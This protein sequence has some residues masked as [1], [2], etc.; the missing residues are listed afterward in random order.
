MTSENIEENKYSNILINNPYSKI[1]DLDTNI[2]SNS[3]QGKLKL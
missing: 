2:D 3:L 1:S